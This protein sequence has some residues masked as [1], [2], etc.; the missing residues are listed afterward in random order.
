M[1]KVAKQHK[2]RPLSALI[3]AK[4]AIFK[5]DLFIYDKSTPKVTPGRKF[6]SWIIQ[7]A[8][9]KHVRASLLCLQVYKQRSTAGEG[10]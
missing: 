2:N 9:I 6:A 4:K 1:R 3:M 10:D 5:L 7:D 8:L